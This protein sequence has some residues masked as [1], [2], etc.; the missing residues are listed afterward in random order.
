[1]SQA[2]HLPFPP[3]LRRH[4]SDQI[5]EHP[6]SNVSPRNTES[7]LRLVLRTSLDMLKPLSIVDRHGPCQPRRSDASDIAEERVLAFNRSPVCLLHDLLVLVRYRKYAVVES[8][9][10]IR[11]V[12]WPTT[13]ACRGHE[14]EGRLV[15]LQTGLF[16]IE[17]AY[18]IDKD[19]CCVTAECRLVDRNESHRVRELPAHFGCSAESGDNHGGK[20]A[21]TACSE[22][23]LDCGLVG[24]IALNDAEL[25]GESAL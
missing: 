15:G 4:I 22:G 3:G 16:G 10:A 1:M 12:F 2:A 9:H 19:M 14:D 20:S 13:D 24:G 8:S 21:C 6:L 18:G 7:L 17:L 11:H 23:G 25:R 5:V